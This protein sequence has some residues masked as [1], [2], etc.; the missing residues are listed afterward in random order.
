MLQ[1]PKKAFPPSAASPGHRGP[2]FGARLPGS[3][4]DCLQGRGR[5]GGVQ[6]GLQNLG[7]K[8]P[9]SPVRKYSSLPDKWVV[10]PGPQANSRYSRWD[11]R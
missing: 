8:S 3:S 10:H 11:G 1:E 2:R 7:L 5:A 6:L 9:H 4:L